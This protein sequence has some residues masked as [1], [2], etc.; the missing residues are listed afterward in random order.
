MPPACSLATREPALNCLTLPIGCP[1]DETRLIHAIEGMYINYRI[2][3]G[4]NHASRN[5]HDPASSANVKVCSLC[6]ETIA[7][8][9]IFVA[10]GQT[11]ATSCMRSPNSFVLCAGVPHSQWSAGP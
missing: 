9:L 10:N 2:S 3:R 5:R 4:S 6:T 1:M 8:Q 11:E 7:V